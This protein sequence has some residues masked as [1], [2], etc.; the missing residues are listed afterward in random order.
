MGEVDTVV[1]LTPGR[2]ESSTY[3]HLKWASQIGN[4]VLVL[5]GCRTQESLDAFTGIAD[6]GMIDIG[7]HK[8]WFGKTD[9]IVGSMIDEI[10]NNQDIT[11]KTRISIVF[12]GG[13]KSIYLQLYHELC[14]NRDFL[15][16]VVDESQIR[17]EIDFTIDEWMHI[18]TNDVVVFDDEQNELRLVENESTTILSNLELGRFENPT[19][20]YAH[21]PMKFRITAEMTY[22][23][24]IE[25]LI[26]YKA[27][28]RKGIEKLNL[29]LVK[30][31]LTTEIRIEPQ[32]IV[33]TPYEK[34]QIYCDSNFL[35]RSLFL[36]LVLEGEPFI[37]FH[38]ANPEIVRRFTILRTKI[39]SK[40]RRK[41]LNKVLTTIAQ[42]NHKLSDVLNANRGR[43][44][45]MKWLLRERALPIVH[46][47][48]HRLITDGF[49]G[50]ELAKIV[51]SSSS[52]VVFQEG[53]DLI[54]YS[55]DYK[56][57]AS[58][59]IISLNVQHYLSVN[60][61][62]FNAAMSSF[63]YKSL[64]Q[65]SDDFSS[66]EKL[67]I[68]GFELKGER[69][70]PHYRFKL[71]DQ[72]QEY[73][74]VASDFCEFLYALAK[75]TQKHEQ[76]FENLW[77]FDADNHIKPYND[78]LKTYGISISNKRHVIDADGYGLI[79]YKKKIHFEISDV[80]CSSEYNS[81]RVLDK[82]EKYEKMASNFPYPIYNT[83]FSVFNRPSEDDLEKEK[84]RIIPFI[85][86]GKNRIWKFLDLSHVSSESELQIEIH[87]TSL[88]EF[89]FD[90]QSEFANIHNFEEWCYLTK[91]DGVSFRLE[92]EE[93]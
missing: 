38:S 55:G 91:N 63:N 35:S 70:I 7:Q 50:R 26:N 20:L 60:D 27:S 10:N 44:D 39:F 18:N 5:A 84:H 93:E 3:L 14:K 40:Q 48:N 89:L 76:L 22:E 77:S 49:N 62:E 9:H 83:V 2:S 64:E 6:G 31:N 81:E 54:K 78:L 43:T 51:N 72:E 73:W 13:K 36:S 86:Q 1:V 85:E 67:T 59:F 41:K 87:L 74:S 79:R 25:G 34:T 4:A 47:D 75:N 11:T 21:Y 19:R 82:Y 46:F 52:P 16:D 37:D 66:H 12:A 68:V 15:V 80:H 69:K 33:Q 29:L 24:I 56:L 71:D 61:D 65:M 30:N 28:I 88:G 92:N 58:A 57:W 17:S 23:E 45:S 53:K 90:V 8:S 42:I 32:I